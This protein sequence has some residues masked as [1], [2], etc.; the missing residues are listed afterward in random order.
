MLS[1]STGPSRL[2]PG[3][4]WPPRDVAVLAALAVCAALAADAVAQGGAAAVETEIDLLIG[5]TNQAYGSSGV[6]HRLGLVAGSDV[7]YSETG[8]GGLDIERLWEPSDGYLD[9]MHDRRD[10][11]GADLV[12]LFVGDGDAGGIA[13]LPRPFGVSLWRGRLPG[14]ANQP[15]A[16]VGTLPDR[17]LVVDSTLS[18]DVSQ[19]FVDPDDDRLSY[20]V[21]SSATHVVTVLAAGA[22]RRWAWVRPRSR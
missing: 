17:T 21:S 9:E 13:Y 1:M 8:M 11:A 2:R 15:P 20:S 7:P 5:E 6:R 14:R 22:R 4:R 16:A 12:H 3:R 10:G 18:M 19:A